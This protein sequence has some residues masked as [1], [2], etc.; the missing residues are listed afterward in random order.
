MRIFIL[1][2]D[3]VRIGFFLRTLSEHIG[4]TDEIHLA[5]DADSAL[6]IFAPPYDLLLLDHDLGGRTYVE[7]HDPNTGYQFLLRVRDRIDTQTHAIVH[8]WNPSGAW[9]MMRLL[10]DEGIPVARH[11]F[12]PKTFEM[13]LPFYI[14]HRR[15]RPVEQAA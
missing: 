11:A 2:D 13:I 4:D 1:E 5:T 9:A 6:F 12:D 14:E 7:S 10:H 3:P 8:S 15:R